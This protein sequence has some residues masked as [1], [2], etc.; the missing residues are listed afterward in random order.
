MKNN[1][2]FMFKLIAATVTGAEPP[3]ANDN[4]SWELL[5][6][7]S[8]MHSITNIIAHPVADNKY[9]MQPEIKEMFAKKL[10]ERVYVCENQNAE[11]QKLILAFE[12]NDISYMPLKGM[13][14]KEMYPSYDMRAMADA[15]ILIKCSEYDKIKGIMDSLGYS[16]QG[17]S[18]HEYNYIKKPFMHIELHKRLIPSY[19]DDMYAY[20]GD[21]W[22]LARECKNSKCRY[23]LSLE[24]NLIYILAH[25]AKH[26]RDG[27]I[28]IK[29]VID[30]WLY[31]TKNKIDEEY[32]KN[33]L[34]EL[35][36]YEFYQNIRKLINAW[37]EDG[38][39][40]DV[41]EQMTLFII[42]SGNFGTINNSMSA[43]AIRESKDA[44][45]AA[46]FKYIK[47]IFPELT[48]MKKIFPILEKMPF[49]LPV[50]WIWRVVRLVLFRRDKIKIHQKNVATIEKNSVKNYQTHME[51]V[52]LD[53]YNGRRKQ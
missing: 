11:I 50:M 23:E 5:Y 25:F 35:N 21:G 29:H 24:D 27:G 1:I 17:E 32:L 37:F 31:C 41:T 33:R 43:T 53:I 10:F 16:F 22:K 40:D 2:L 26:Y 49:L 38:E 46:R 42:N 12:E 36:I 39:F 13:I 30:I 19:N 48:K 14:L 52:G 47:F 4:I 44:D 6:K 18:D 51:M 20:F 3:E 28:G 8:G 9:D 15:D 34:K 7:I 45:N